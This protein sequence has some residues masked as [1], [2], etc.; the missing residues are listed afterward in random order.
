MLPSPQIGQYVRLED[1]GGRLIVKAV[2]EDG[3]RVDLVSECDPT[4]VRNDVRCVDL[5]LAEDYS[6]ES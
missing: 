4:Y 3:G 5:L 6:A 2:S 1:Y